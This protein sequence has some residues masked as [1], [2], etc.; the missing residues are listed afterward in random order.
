M[1]NRPEEKQSVLLGLMENNVNP[2]EVV[3]YHYNGV[4]WKFK[5]LVTSV[6]YLPVP[7]QIKSWTSKFCT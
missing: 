2:Y 5:C 7:V 1:Q 6:A 4:Y 3:A